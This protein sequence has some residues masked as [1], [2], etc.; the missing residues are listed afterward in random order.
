MFLAEVWD[1]RV[2]LAVLRWGGRGGVLR[3]GDAAFFVR[4]LAKGLEE[5]RVAPPLIGPKISWRDTASIRRRTTVPREAE[6][7][8]KI[9]VVVHDSRKVQA[10]L[11]METNLEKFLQISRRWTRYDVDLMN[12]RSLICCSSWRLSSRTPIPH[13]VLVSHLD[14]THYCKNGRGRLFL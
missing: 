10:G 4:G 5:S 1:Y 11:N 3:S 9:V 8:R 7:S 14:F 6:L 2:E 12:E 13:P